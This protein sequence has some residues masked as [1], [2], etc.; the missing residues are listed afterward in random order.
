MS[1]YDARRVGVKSAIRRDKCSAPLRVSKSVALVGTGLG[2]FAKSVTTGAGD[3]WSASFFIPDR[4][5]TIY[6]LATRQKVAPFKSS[7]HLARSFD[8]S[9]A[10]AGKPAPTG[11]YGVIKISATPENLWE[12]ACQLPQAMMLLPR[13]Q[14]HQK[15]CE[16]WLASS[17]RHD[18][19][20]KMSATPENLWELACQRLGSPRFQHSTALTANPP[21]EVSLYLSCISAPVS[22]MVRITRSS[23]MKC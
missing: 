13:C 18:G 10:I 7:V 23:E 4:A 2:A 20:T 5:V 3:E 15:I 17:H 8:W 9:G 6:L 1:I 22:R 14:L 12:L 19:V 16:S 11:I 21:R